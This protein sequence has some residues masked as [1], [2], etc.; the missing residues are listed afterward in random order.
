MA[1]L[2]D[3]IGADQSVAFWPEFEGTGIPAS[4]GRSSLLAFKLAA[5][6]K[7]SVDA[8]QGVCPLLPQPSKLG[9]YVVDDDGRLL[10]AEF[11][12]TAGRRVESLWSWSSTICGETFMGRTATRRR[13][14]G[15]SRSL[16]TSMAAIRL[17]PA[18]SNV[19]SRRG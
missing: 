7:A 10:H 6:R 2:A 12:R 11:S 1:E 8:N 16:S 13:R 14:D 3:E 17:W 5:A 4:D 9:G 19:W 15:W 18:W